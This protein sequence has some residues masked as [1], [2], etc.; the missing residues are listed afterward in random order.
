MSFN[1]IGI[2]QSYEFFAT[3]T[4]L[5]GQSAYQ[6]Q[7]TDLSDDW[8]NLA[9]KPNKTQADLIKLDTEYKKGFINFGK[10][11][12]THLDKTYGNGDGSLTIDEYVKSQT[13]AL[14]EEY[15]KDAEFIQATKN[16]FHNINVNGGKTI[17]EKE[18]T[19]LL[20]LFDMDVNTGGLNGKI[21]VYD[22]LAFSLSLIESPNS[23]SG[24]N[25]QKKIT[26]RYT[27]IFSK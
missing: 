21:K 11:Y 27:S 24:K 18:M 17:D 26:E 13:N 12:I 7:F 14:P 25:M 22:T 4:G 3:R 1:N 19:A 16:S 23:D 8:R 9:N 15:K 6:E 20:S 5:A 2:G 10:S